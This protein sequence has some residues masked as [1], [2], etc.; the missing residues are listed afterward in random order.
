M[1]K[2]IILH[3]SQLESEM[4]DSEMAAMFF[5][6]IVCYCDS[7]FAHKMAPYIEVSLHLIDIVMR[8]LGARGDTTMRARC[9]R[10]APGGTDGGRYAGSLRGDVT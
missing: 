9:E 3:Q 8:L 5:T 1:L 4:A 7:E 6:S 2:A 10:F